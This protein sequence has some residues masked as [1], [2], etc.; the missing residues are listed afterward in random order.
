MHYYGYMG[1]VSFWDVLGHIVIVLLVIWLVIRIVCGPRWSRRW[2]RGMGGPGMWQ[3]HNALQ[4][5]NERFAKGEINKE[6]Y[7]ERKKTLLG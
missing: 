4:I 1:G 5:L 6:E 2:G 3:S 7:E